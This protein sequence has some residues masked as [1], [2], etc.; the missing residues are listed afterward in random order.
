M[1][2]C[3]IVRHD[4]ALSDSGTALGIARIFSRPP[5]RSA[6]F[7]P[8][9]TR[10]RLRAFA[11]AAFSWKPRAVRNPE[12]TFG[13]PDNGHSNLPFNVAAWKFHAIFA[14]A[15]MIQEIRN[16]GWSSNRMSS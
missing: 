16:A 9:R 4:A 1:P 8:K 14:T 3:G 11:V 5:T 10:R 2:V 7:L 13:I 6:F 12:R 15:C